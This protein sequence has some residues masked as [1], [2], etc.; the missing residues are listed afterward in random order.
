MKNFKKFLEEV[1]IKGNPGIPGE[2]PKR[3]GETGYLNNVENRAKN[4]LDITARDLQRVPGRPSETEMRL[5]RRMMELLPQSIQLSHGYET[6]LSELATNIITNLYSDIIN[7][8]NIELDIKLVRPGTIKNFMDESEQDEMDMPKF[9]EIKDENVRKEIHKRKLANLVIQGEAKNTKHLLHTEEVKEGL[10]DILGEQNGKRLFT[11]LDE[12][13]KT[14]DKMDWIVPEEI[15]A[16]MMEEMPDGMAGACSVGWKPK[17]KKEDEEDEEGKE[18]AIEEPKDEEDGEQEEDLPMEDGATPILRARGIDFSMLLHEAVKGLFEIL[19]L[20]GIPEDKEVS[21]LVIS[22]TGLSD[23]PQDFK[24]GPEI[25]SDLRD[26]VNQN[27]KV[28]K[29]P[30]VREELWKLMIDKESM[31]TDEFLEL[32]RGILS[33]TEKAKREVDRLLTKVIKLIEE[34]K[35]GIDDYNRKM[36]EYERELRDYEEEKN[37]PKNKYEEEEDGEFA[38]G[39]KEEE[40]DIDKLVKQSLNNKDESPTSNEPDYSRM[41]AKELDFAMNQALDNEDYQLAHKISQFTKS[42]SRRIYQRELKIINEKLNP[43]QKLK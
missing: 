31:P 22:N 13:A 24:Y 2:G 9:R 30:N 4:R 3:P 39:G 41:S 23:E 28:D 34:E 26:F 10:I 29:Y 38:T 19:S 43:H 17:E 42:E 32:M 14:A 25:A 15:K 12:L 35:S 1:D 37:R 33:K 40:S 11:V 16:Q 5:G 18:I 36:D 7:R 21:K 8:Y 27:D 20:G 6:E